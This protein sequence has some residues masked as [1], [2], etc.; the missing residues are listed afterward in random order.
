M[1]DPVSTSCICA[2]GH[3]VSCKAQPCSRNLLPLIVLVPI[4]AMRVASRAV[5]I[6][7][8]NVLA[9]SQAGTKAAGRAVQNTCDCSHLSKINSL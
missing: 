7:E 3:D 8:V 2:Q 4:K 9:A 1:L 5:L 6:P